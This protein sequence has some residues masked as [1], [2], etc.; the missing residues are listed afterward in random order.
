[1]TTLAVAEDD[2]RRV[3]GLSL[4]DLLL[5]EI[6]EL[7]HIKVFLLDEGA[8]VADLHQSWKF[9]SQMICCQQ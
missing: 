9:G 8:D 5:S 7:T 1:M 4:K 2:A 3:S 6:L